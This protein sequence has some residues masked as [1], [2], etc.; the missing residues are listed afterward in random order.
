ML[1]HGGEPLHDILLMLY[2][3]IINGHA[4]IPA[5]WKK[6]VVKVLHKSG[7]MRLP[8][9]YR[10]ISIIPLLYKL[11][12]RLLCNRLLPVLDSEQS[13]DQ[14]GFRPGKSTTDHLFTIG[15]L[16]ETAEEWQTPLWI[17]AIDFKKAF[18]SV[19]H[20]GIW[21]ALASKGVDLC[22]INLLKDMCRN[23]TATVR[24][25]KMSQPF[26]IQRGTK[27][28]DPL[29]SLLFNSVSEYVI[30]NMRAKWGKAK[31]GI[32][33]HVADKMLLSNLRFAG[34]ILFVA[35][36][37]HQVSR[38]I[39]NLSAEAA[40]VGLQVHP[41]STKILHNAYWIYQR[42]RIPKTVSI[43]G[44]AIEVLDVKAHT[45][46][47]GR[48]LSFYEPNRVEIENR[49]ACAWRK[50]HALRQELTGK[51]YSLH[52][53]LRL[54]NGVVTPTILYGCEAWTMTQEL[55][56]RVK[57]TQ[58]Q[59]L[60][61]IIHLP[62]RVS[63]RREEPSGP[64]DRA[65][66]VPS[67]D[68]GSDVAS[69][70]AEEDAQHQRHEAEAADDTTNLESWV[71][72]IKRSTREAEKHMSSLGIDDWIQQQR[73][74]K[75]RWFQHVAQSFSCEW[76]HKVLMWSPP[77]HPKLISQR[78]QSRPKRRWLD[79]IM[80]FTL[81]FADRFQHEA[82]T[83]LTEAGC[84]QDAAPFLMKLACTSTWADLEGDF[85]DFSIAQTRS[86]S[87]V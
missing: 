75:W 6:T 58:R 3:D 67:T 4:P 22:Y 46:Y 41:D 76:M 42:T 78:R 19:T 69:V 9:N 43:N 35:S 73:R 32:G 20:R 7:D 36:S 30:R 72:W 80:S 2:N 53:R 33:M 74:R 84:V 24:T 38:M 50:F 60:R 34:D 45:K 70:L 79:D 5:A 57:R 87:A 64:Q 81:L 49:M 39:A 21:D 63:E 65:D 18:D 51:R 55:Q 11:F 48:K 47:L 59:M 23:Q 40:A 29:S 56:N 16:Q 52:D 82:K 15:I 86:D 71:E 85:V 44:M 66:S 83:R 1:K 54:F 62:R 14:A 8:Q 68:S 10:P 17:A 25:D 28:G 12:S 27:Q 26:C 37:L 77:E 31:I 13:P 61:M